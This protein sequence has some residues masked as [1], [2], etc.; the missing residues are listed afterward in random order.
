[1]IVRVFWRDG[2]RSALSQ[3]TSLLLKYAS[4]ANC[5]LHVRWIL[6]PYTECPGRTVTVLTRSALVEF[7]ITFQFIASWSSRK[8]RVLFYYNVKFPTDHPLA[9]QA[10]LFASLSL[11]PAITWPF[12]PTNGSVPHMANCLL[13]S[14]LL[15][16]LCCIVTIRDYYRVLFYYKQ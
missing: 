15:T 8:Y 5:F 13:T 12:S 11:S 3:S 9:K 16:Y 14:Y 10:R 1:V 7:Q 2:S 4:D 6:H